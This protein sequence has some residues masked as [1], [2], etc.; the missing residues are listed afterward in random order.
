MVHEDVHCDR[1]SCPGPFSADGLR[2]VSESCDTTDRL[3]SVQAHELIRAGF[4][5]YSDKVRWVSESS[6]GIFVMSQ[7]CSPD[8]IILDRRSR[9]NMWSLLAGN[10]NIEFES[11]RN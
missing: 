4:Q 3:R 6:D 8:T 9:A 1:G 10:A 11:I 7:G 2:I 5:G